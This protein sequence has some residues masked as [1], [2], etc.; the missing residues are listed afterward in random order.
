MDLPEFKK[1]KDLLTQI[2]LLLLLTIKVQTIE[3]GEGG[4]YFKELSPGL[5]F[6]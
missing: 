1:Y 2:F 3:R 6:T 4:K 5:R